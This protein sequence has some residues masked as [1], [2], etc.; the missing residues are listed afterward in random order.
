MANNLSYIYIDTGAMY[1][2]LTLEALNK[3]VDVNDGQEL[4][5]LLSQTK[6]ELIQSNNGQNILINKVDVTSEIRS[7]RVTNQVSYVAKHPEVREE[8][9]IRQQALATKQGVVM[10]GRDIGTH[11]L[12]SA[13]LKIFLIATVEERAKRRYEENIQKGIS[14]D[15]EVLKKEIEQRDRL[16]SNRKVAPLVKADD[17]IEI[18]TTSLSIEE[19]VQRI[20]TKASALINGK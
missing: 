2:A 17:A 14:T 5:K 13:G 8:M 10:D 12:P 1:R 6:I 20:L 7:Q 16:D 19:V 18:D 4:A 11:V 15:L 3:N 9:V